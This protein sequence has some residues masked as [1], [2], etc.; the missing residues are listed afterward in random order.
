MLPDPICVMEG[1]E[2]RPASDPD[3]AK[4]LADMTGIIW[5]EEIDEG[6]YSVFEENIA[7]FPAGHMLA[8]AHGQVVGTAAGFAVGHLP[9]FNELNKGVYSLVV[10]SGSVYY[11]HL[12]QVLSAYRRR[13][14]GDA[15][16]KAQIA[17]ARSHRCH[18]IAG[19]SAESSLAHWLKSGFSAFGDW[20][21]YHHYGRFRLVRMAIK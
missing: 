13:G 17:V 18:E 3:G 20:G 15:L 16:L 2:I 7:R 8:T 12:I 10:P 9:N 5:G 11:I 1:F 4:A 21:Q 6:D 14:I 19:I